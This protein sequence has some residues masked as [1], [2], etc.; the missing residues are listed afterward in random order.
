[1]NELIKIEIKPSQAQT[2]TRNG[3][4]KKDNKPYSIHEQN[5]YIFLGG[6][7]PE[8]FKL[9]LDNEQGAYPAGFYSLHESCFYVGEFNKL[10]IGKIK[11]VPLKEK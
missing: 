2:T 11:L 9:V 7:Y 6:D 4:S 8:L 1:V 3:I 5:A 10:K